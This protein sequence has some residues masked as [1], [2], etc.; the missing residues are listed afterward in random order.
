MD[1]DQT[2]L[3]PHCELRFRT[4][5]E[6]RE[7]IEREHPALMEEE[8]EVVP[9]PTG[10][11]VVAVDPARPPGE[12]VAVAAAFATQTGQTLDLVAVPAPGLGRV[13]ADAYLRARVHDARNTGVATIAWTTLGEGDPAAAVL[14]HLDAGGGTM[15]CV[16][17]RA[18]SAIKEFLLGSVSEPVVRQAPIP[19][20]LVGPRCTAPPGGFTRVVACFE[21][22]DNDAAIRTTAA[23]LA[24][25]A[26]VPAE[27]FRALA[28]DGETPLA[29]GAA[30]EAILQELGG[31]PATIAVLG[32]KGRKGFERVL[33]ESVALEVTRQA[34]G[35]VIVVPPNA[36]QD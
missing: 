24:D 35:P 7:H 14:Q 32:T 23:Q 9:S 33:A 6:W 36:A 21:D 34:R 20:L 25:R 3:C 22:P 19:V 10:Q 31:D 4:T 8:A 16:G 13:A 28:P 5:T 11:L 1:P 18:R 27:E 30:T 2:H 26:S 17:T 15:V 29:D 12:E